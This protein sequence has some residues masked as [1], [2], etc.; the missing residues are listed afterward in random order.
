MEKAPLR[1]ICVK[2]SPMLKKNILCE[3]LKGSVQHMQNMFNVVGSLNIHCP[4]FLTV[5]DK[6][7]NWIRRAEHNDNLAWA[8]VYCE[9][10]GRLLLSKPRVGYR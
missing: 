8:S 3:Y 1:L 7:K 9:F 2:F 5:K 6:R 10:L 4:I